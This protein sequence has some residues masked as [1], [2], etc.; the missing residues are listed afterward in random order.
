MR[1]AVSTHRRNRALAGHSRFRF[2]VAEPVAQGNPLLA[3]AMLSANDVVA[4][5]PAGRIMRT[6]DGDATRRLQSSRTTN[7]LSGVSFTDANTG[8]A[9][10]FGGTILRTTDG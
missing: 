10:G 4:D 5:G 9:V 7:I 6:T 1:N 2:D 8:T 3:T